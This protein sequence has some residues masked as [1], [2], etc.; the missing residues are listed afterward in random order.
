MTKTE[1]LEANPDRPKR[2]LALDG[3][4]IRGRLSLEYLG[5]IEQILR[6]RSE[7]EDFR[8]C[9]YFDL[10]GGTSTGAILAATLACGASVEE[11]KKLYETLGSTVFKASMFRKGVLA[12]KFPAGPLQQALEGCLHDAT[13]GGE[14][15]RT[16][17]MIMTKRLD[18]G[19]PWPIHNGPLSPYAKQNGALRLSEIVRAS[20]AAP[21]YFA[22]EEVAISS[23]SGEVVKAAFVDGGVSPFN[24]PALE[25]L[26]AA[27]VEGYGFRW[28]SGADR[29]LV[30]SVGTGTRHQSRSTAEIMGWPAAE[31][32]VRSLQALM[33]DCS[34]V[35]LTVMQWLTRCLT[36]WTVDREVGDMKGDSAA[37]PKLATY[38]RYNVILE[39]GWL[40][41]ELGISRSPEQLEQLAQ[42]D[43]PEN[44]GELIEVGR[45]A[46]LKQVKAEHFPTVFDL[47]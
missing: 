43:R 19:S 7:R 42:M 31:Q 20:A 34:R 25:L 13:L 33:D 9:D 38:A 17:L 3:G 44:M 47:R 41:D 6:D 35:N 22:P 15:V 45:A 26:L 30:I 8:L 12:A 29:L 32:G 40:K 14:A 21:T 28:K 4:G 5:V 18:T 23:R 37:G 24:D 11:L 39:Q 46:A 2:I 27:V 10:I 1:H 16:G 36:P